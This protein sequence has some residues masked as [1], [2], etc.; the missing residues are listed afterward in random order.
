MPRYIDLVKNEKLSSFKFNEP[1]APYTSWR[2]GGAG[3]L[4][5]APASEEEIYD[6][7]MFAQTYHIPLTPLGG[8]SNVLLS[9][10][11]LKGIV[12]HITHRFSAIEMQPDGYVRAQAGARLGT[13]IRKA[14]DQNL[15]G[16]E[17]LWGIP[18]T[19][20]GAVAMN[21]GACNSEF[22]DH[23]VSVKSLTREGKL[24]TRYKPEI[25]HGYRFSDYKTNGE[26]VL[27]ATLQLQPAETTL[28]QHNFLLADE[29]RK[30]QHNIRQPNAGSVF[31]NPV[32]NYAARLIEGMG[33]KGRRVGQA[34]VSLDHANF[35]VNLG[36][37]RSTDVRQLI[38]SL[39][40]DVWEHYEIDIHPEVL[41]LGEFATEPL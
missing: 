40:Q 33:A 8:G 10:Q 7:L 35:I 17:Q 29:R 22:F 38:H 32:N 2:I 30:P 18:G 27:E 11:G 23:L 26:I 28:I 41:L 12:L 16:I 6:I 3:E 24:V 34:Q 4:Y 19:V 36:H 37:A 14:M 1:L 31:R 5:V 9:D 39:R 20:G 21:A 15:S 25:E 13:I